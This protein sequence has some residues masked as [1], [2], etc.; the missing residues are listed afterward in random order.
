MIPSLGISV[1]VNAGGWEKALPEAVRIGRLTARRGLKAGLGH[2]N[3]AIRC[4]GALARLELT[5]VL[6][7]DRGVRRLN[8]AWRGKDRPTNVLSFAAIDGGL[9]KTH[10]AAMP[11]HLGDVVLALETLKTEARAQGKKFTQHFQHLVVHG[12]LHLLGFDHAGD[13]DAR[14]MEDLERVVLAGF[15]WPDPYRSQ[16][17]E[18]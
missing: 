15:G 2:S 6:D 11:Y 9:P 1:A 10:P 16:L 8:S 14:V 5:L 12:V 18:R 13:K 3:P 7:S 17:E 4:L